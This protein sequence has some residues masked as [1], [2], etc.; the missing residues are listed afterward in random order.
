MYYYIIV[1]YVCLIC[2]SEHVHACV[3][4]VKGLKGVCVCEGGGSQQYDTTSFI[5]WGEQ[6]AC[7]SWDAHAL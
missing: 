2:A 3:C 7:Y 4:S 5:H 6:C 1:V